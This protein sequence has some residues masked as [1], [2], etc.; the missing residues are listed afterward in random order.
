MAKLFALD[1]NIMDTDKKKEYGT[2]FS[3]DARNGE[4]LM[5]S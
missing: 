1:G 3:V 5:Q 4:R 2:R